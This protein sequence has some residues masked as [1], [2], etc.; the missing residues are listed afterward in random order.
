MYDRYGRMKLRMGWGERRT[1][2]YALLYTH[3]SDV[4]VSAGSRIT[5]FFL[6]SDSESALGIGRLINYT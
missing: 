6:L 3:I 4:E 5:S 2:G 1:T